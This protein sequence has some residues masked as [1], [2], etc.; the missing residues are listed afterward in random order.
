[1]NKYA[2][3][4]IAAFLIIVVG[5]FFGLALWDIPAPSETVEVELDDSRFPR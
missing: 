3:L 4:G 2:L 5:G 1:M